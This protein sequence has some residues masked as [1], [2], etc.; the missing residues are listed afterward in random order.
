[1]KRLQLRSRADVR[2]HGRGCV[3]V[4]G[5]G[6]FHDFVFRLFLFTQ[7][8]ELLPAVCLHSGPPSMLCWHSDTFYRECLSLTD[9]LTPPPPQ[10]QIQ[11][12]EKGLVTKLELAFFTA[13]LI[14]GAPPHTPPHPKE[15]GAQ[16]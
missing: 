8:A 3:C 7:E 12:G 15:W 6:L 11:R 2:M 1:M 4:W 16:N 14:D 13:A 9:C 10:A 5:G